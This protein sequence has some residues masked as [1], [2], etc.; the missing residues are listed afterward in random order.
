V[1]AGASYGLGAAFAFHLASL[2]LNVVLVARSADKL[3][4]LA[5][6]LAS[7]YHIQVRTLSQDLSV[8]DAA[9][10]ITTRA[11]DLEIGLLVC[12]AAV[13]CIGPFVETSLE[14]HQR[15]IQV[16]VSTPLALTYLFGQKMVQR[17]KGGIILMSSL[18]STQGSPMVSN[19]AATKAYLRILSEGL[20]DEFRPAGVDVI[21]CWAGSIDTPGFNG[22][23]QKGKA[24]SP[25]RSLPPDKVARET[26]ESLGHRPWVIPGVTNRAAAFFMQRF[27]PRRMA[28]V[29]MG[30][31]LRKMYE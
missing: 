5:A 16:N 11:A 10:Q 17:G 6:Q 12:N 27:L 26:L 15:E 25:I 3:E 19:Y 4:A 30:R 22:S 20:W 1:V 13:S 31:V 8:P 14:D 29:M 7:Q 18:S 21:A 2:G 24:N 23:I 28:V 9:D